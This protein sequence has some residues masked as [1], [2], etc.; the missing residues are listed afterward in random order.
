M[1]RRGLVP[2]R[3]R[4][5]DL[6]DAK[7]VTVGGAPALKPARMVA[8]D[9]SIEVVGPPPRFVSRGGLKLDAALVEFDLDVAGSTVLDA[10]AGTGGFTDCLLQ[11]G[12][13]RVVALDV[14]SG[15]LHQRLRDDPRVVVVERF[16]ARTLTAA[17][18]GGEVDL[19][20][21]DLS[22]I[23]L[24]AVI[25]ALLSCL[26][27]GGDLILLVKPQFEAG[28]READRG[29]GVV[30]SP[31]VWLDVLET[32]KDAVLERKASI[33]GVMPSPITGAN[34]NV[35]F[36]VHIGKDG[37]GYLGAD[38]SQAVSRALEGIDRWPRSP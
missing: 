14:G 15:Q 2:S 1:L 5:R 4:A 34:G 23:S 25:D 31:E 19:V 13:A 3:R 30:R 11:R 21:A 17:G 27:E 8:A 26:I 33:M 10:G 12:A 28:K 35:E 6:I 22:F 9:E 37:R 29:Q 18:V 7:R 20:T 36:L 38:L 32:L 24:R 16:N